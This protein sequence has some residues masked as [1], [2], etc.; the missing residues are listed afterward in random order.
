MIIYNRRLRCPSPKG[1]LCFCDSYIY[2][3]EWGN[4]PC[5][6]RAEMDGSNVVKITEDSSVGRA[7]S[8]TI[9]YE[10]QRLYFVDLEINEIIS[11]D[12]NGEAGLRLPAEHRAENTFAVSLCVV[13]VN[14][15]RTCGRITPL[16]LLWLLL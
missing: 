5:I 14:R 12:M 4:V 13:F 16:L 15:F 11:M 10:A 9:D 3:S 2:W 8:L 1:S 7:N 6:K